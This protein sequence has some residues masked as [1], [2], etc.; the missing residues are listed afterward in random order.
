VTGGAGFIGRHLVDKLITD[1]SE[2][3]II[4]SGQTGQLAS[5]AKE[6]R[7]INVDLDSYEINDFME[8]LHGV[9][10]VFHLAA[11]KHN[12]ADISP[13]KMISTNVLS[14][15]NLIIASAKS[16]V[17]R[18]VFTSSLYTYGN[19]GPRIMNEGDLPKPSTLYGSSK[20]MGENIL[21][22]AEKQYGLN[23][24]VAR[25]YFIYGPGQFAGSG[26]KSVIVK[27]FERIRDGMPVI[28]NGDGNQS[29]DYLYVQDAVEGIKKLAN[30]KIQN[31]IFNV[32]SG[33]LISINDLLLLMK[34]VSG[35]SVES[36]YESADW[37][38]GSKR[39]G[40]NS[41]I[42]EKLGWAPT[43]SMFDG[44][45][46]TWNFINNSKESGRLDE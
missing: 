25:L 39:F 31:N 16:K 1:Y 6:A 26:Y 9:D 28:I 35:K 38:S 41:L 14:T 42:R 10:H 37:T 44:L 7:L 17:K 12:T 2:V 15:Y 29:L 19:L 22:F 13:R 11:Q 34:K 43:V 21:R 20:L 23:W 4:D 3:I 46:K 8:I 32:S 24:N 45:K 36:I 18:F 5:V 33:S 40:D 27:N 30:C